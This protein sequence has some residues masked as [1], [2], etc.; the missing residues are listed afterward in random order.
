[1]LIDTHCHIDNR[2]YIDDVEEVIQRANEQGVE[3]I[4]IPG[5]S[6]DDLPRAI[7]L[8]EKHKNIFFAVGIH[9]YDIEHFD[10]KPFYEYANHPK[11]IAVGECGLDYFRLPKDDTKDEVIAR[12][13]EV[14]IKQIEIANE[15]NKPLI[16]HIREASKDSKD[17]LLKHS[18]VKGVLHCYNADEILLDMAD[19]GYYYGI[20]GVLTFKNAK[21]LPQVLKKI[22]KDK[23]VIETD[24][25]Y[26]T[27]HPHR[28]TRNEPCYVN[29]VAKK[30][31]QILDMSYEE[32]CSSTTQ[33][34]KELFKEFY[35]ID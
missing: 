1:V 2:Q 27:P 12:Q 16:V 4:L 7:A 17:I 20:G 24:A 18:K 8:S 28:G 25:P 31:S 35:Q 13:K 30:M 14:F 26:L 6:F 5:A 21:A 11:C 9:P 32:V 22:P 15:L 3:S 29:H 10:E 23:L 19:E 33:N 34:A